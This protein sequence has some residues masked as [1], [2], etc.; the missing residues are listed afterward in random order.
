[1][2]V[3]VL[4]TWLAAFLF[5]GKEFDSNETFNFVACAEVVDCDNIV[6][7]FE[8]VDFC[9]NEVRGELVDISL[10]LVACCSANDHLGWRKELRLKDICV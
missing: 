1:S 6:K 7:V 3:S 5:L 2:E 8:V 9:C 10:L 4:A